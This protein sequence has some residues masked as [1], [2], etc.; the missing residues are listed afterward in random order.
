MRIKESIKS[1]VG[2]WDGPNYSLGG[3]VLGPILTGVLLVI[4]FLTEEMVVSKAS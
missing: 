3:V 4:I 2:G 1:P